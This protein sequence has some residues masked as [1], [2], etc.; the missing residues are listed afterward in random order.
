MSRPENRTGGSVVPPEP[1]CGVPSDLGAPKR[2]VE[3]NV[4]SEPLSPVDVA[5][6][7]TVE[8]IDRAVQCE[9]DTSAYY[10]DAHRQHE[11]RM[12]S[13]RRM[14]A[15]LQGMLHGPSNAEN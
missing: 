10:D 4:V 5:C 15:I 11:E 3:D 6:Q 14:R 13:L 8:C 9:L 2:S 7:E 1:N 12:E